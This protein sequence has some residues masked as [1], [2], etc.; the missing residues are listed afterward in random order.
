[1]MSVYILYKLI[2][3]FNKLLIFYIKILLLQM[4]SRDSNKNNV[5]LTKLLNL[6][7]SKM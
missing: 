5:Y 6:T 2:Y 7:N 3:S 1:M 4:N